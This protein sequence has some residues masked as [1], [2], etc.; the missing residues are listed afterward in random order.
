MGGTRRGVIHLV[1]PHGPS[2]AAPDA[3]GRNLGVRL[4]RRM[5]VVHHAWTDRGVIEP[6]PGDV[7]VGHP[8]PARS[9][10]FRRSVRRPGWRRIIMLAPFNLDPAQVAFVDSIIRRCDLFLAISGNH[11]FEHLATSPFS[12]WAPKMRRL[13]MAIDRADFPVL[14]TRFA[15]PGDRGLAYIGHTGPMK[16]TAYLSEIADHLEGV[17]FGW[18]GSGDR[19]IRGLQAFGQQDFATPA[20]RAAVS[21]HDFVVS[22]SSADANPTTMLEAMAWGLIPICTPQSGYDSVPGIVNVPLGDAAA[23]AAV[24]RGWLNRPEEDLLAVQAAN[25][26]R[27]EHIYSWDVFADR[28]FE[29]IESPE[30]PALGSDSLARRLRLVMAATRSRWSGY[31]N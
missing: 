14:K 19:P 3:I 28:V 10:I 20:G 15:A 5:P 17:G 30:S 26:A 8:H 13:D 6:E 21:R 22:V 7:L 9:T 16:N 31:D 29:A 27:L 12:H 2:I 24:I 18:I 23:A 25:R 4:A 11:W 1:Y